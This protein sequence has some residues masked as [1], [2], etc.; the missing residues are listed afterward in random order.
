MQKFAQVAAS[1]SGFIELDQMYF[2]RIQYLFPVYSSTNLSPGL[3]QDK[4]FGV[5]YTQAH[6]FSALAFLP[7]FPE[8][9][10]F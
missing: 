2:R 7:A 5:Y 4:A 9:V 8:R 3:W 6:A 1:K 10:S